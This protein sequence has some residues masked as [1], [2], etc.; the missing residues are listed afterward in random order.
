MKYKNVNVLVYRESKDK[1][2]FLENKC[3]HLGCSLT[4]ND[5]DKLWECKCHGSIFDK[6]GHVIYGPAIKDLKKIN[7]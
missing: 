4:W 5:V 2:I 3:T 1:Y 7:Y 6:H